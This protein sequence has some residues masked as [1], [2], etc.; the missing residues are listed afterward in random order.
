[1]GTSQAGRVKLRVLVVDDDR[2]TAHSSVQVLKFLGYDAL[3][4]Y[5]AAQAK[6][7]AATATPQIVLLDIAMPGEDGFRLAR[8]LRQL[9]GMERALLVC[10]S[11]YGTEAD[12]QKARE[13]GCD[14]HFT[15]PVDWQE[16]IPLFSSRMPNDK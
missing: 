6:K 16:L 2:D 8:D 7:I 4:A 5:D 1:M 12:K 15:K 3:A 10:V 13:A 14:H 11:G 9:P